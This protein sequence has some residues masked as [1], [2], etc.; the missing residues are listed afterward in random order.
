MPRAFSFYTFDWLAYSIFQY[1]SSSCIIFIEY[2]IMFGVAKHMYLYF[3]SMTWWKA[4]IIGTWWSIIMMRLQ[5]LSLSPAGRLIALHGAVVF[6]HNDK[7]HI[8]LQ[9]DWDPDSKNVCPSVITLGLSRN[10]WYSNLVFLSYNAS[11]ES[12]YRVLQY[13]A[14]FIY[15]VRFFFQ[16]FDRF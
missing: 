9:R 1:F 7:C 10:S 11:L 3:K 4:S 6:H 13:Y 5:V 8:S 14:D 12:S 15:E 2:L 16:F